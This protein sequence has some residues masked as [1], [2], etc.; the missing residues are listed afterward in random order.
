MALS[1]QKIQH[2]RIP[3]YGDVQFGAAKFSGADLTVKIK[4]RMKRVYMVKITPTTDAVAAYKVNNAAGTGLTSYGDLI[5]DTD[6]TLTVTRAAGGTSAGEFLYEI[7]GI[8]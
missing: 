3:G 5:P 4:C 2:A 1:A 7:I 8:N 6:G